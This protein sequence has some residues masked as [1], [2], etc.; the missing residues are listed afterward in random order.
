M[1]LQWIEDPLA[2]GIAQAATAILLAIA[3]MLIARRQRIHLERETLV[4]LA[5]GL[6][7]ITLVGSVLL[8][9]LQIPT[10]SSLL[11]LTAMLAAAGM[12]GANRAEGIPGRLIVC[13]QGI[14]LGAGAAIL[15]M[16]AIGVIEW[17]TNSLIPVG[18]MLIANAMNATALALERFRAEIQAHVGEIETALA[19]GAEPHQAVRRYV[20]A[21]TQASLIPRI[22]SLQSLGIVWIP[23]LMTGLL[24]GN[25]NPIYAALY[26]FVIIATMYASGGLAAMAT[27]LWTRDRIFTPAMQLL[28]RPQAAKQEKH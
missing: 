10:W 28:L 21:A 11:A 16:L 23:G 7:Q 12:M 6:V 14:A 26:Q 19:L 15:L 9:L 4:A 24:L 1:L 27:L 13:L 22:N 3:V 2:L 5:R 25:E 8:A 17:Q 18:S 20:Q